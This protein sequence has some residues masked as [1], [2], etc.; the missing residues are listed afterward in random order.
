MPRK[1]LDRIPKRRRRSLH[2]RSN[3]ASNVNQN[4]NISSQNITAPLR[5]NRD[6]ENDSPNLFASSIVNNN[7]HPDVSTN[8]TFFN[9]PIVIPSLPL[10]SPSNENVIM[11]D[12]MQQ[13]TNLP[14]NIQIQNSSSTISSMTTSLFDIQASSSNTD[15]DSDKSS[16]TNQFS[17]TLS[18]E[19]KSRRLSLFTKP[20][21][22][23]DR[24]AY[25]RKRHLIQ[26]LKRTLKALGSDEQGGVILQEALND[27]DF[28][29]LKKKARLVTT[30][31]HSFYSNVTNN[32]F[33]CVKQ[34]SNKT[35]SR[36][37]LN[38]KERIA[39]DLLVTGV[40]PSPSNPFYQSSHTLQYT[41]KILVEHSNV[42][43]TTA[44]R[45][46]QL[47]TS[48]KAILSNPAEHNTTWCVLR[49]RSHYKTMQRT[50]RDE[51]VN[52]IL[53]HEHVIPSSQTADTILILNPITQQREPV[54]KLLLQI[55]VREL[56][57]DLI[58]PPP[59]GLP[60]VYDSSTQKLLVS[61]ST[62]RAMLPPQL[63][64]MTNAQKEICGCECCITTKLLHQALLHFRSNNKTLRSM[65]YLDNFLNGAI[66]IKTDLTKNESFASN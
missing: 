23:T 62:L 61:E 10:N 65:T 8:N 22:K 37:R 16:C 42:P 56:H 21:D 11:I 17:V 20:S 38:D 58:G 26:K 52:W 45:I 31:E 15:K 18:A 64:R 28:Q 53:S 41:K 5:N 13:Q 2:R 47:G 1:Y 44:R 27:P 59:K 29:N 63:R 4:R 46:L 48:R 24:S 32:L 19:E 9:E 6:V 43:E 3:I 54:T 60:S 55:S 14:T 12:D 39:R 51:L 40:V 33:K 25:E 66:N 30:E 7:N 35:H 57:D 50:L 49:E 36:G 34:V